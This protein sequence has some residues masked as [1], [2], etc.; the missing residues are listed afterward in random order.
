VRVTDLL[1]EGGHVVGVAAVD[2]AGRALS[3]RARLVVGADG[4]G[5]VVAHQ[6]GCRR[7]HRLRR[8]ALVTYVRG[9]A[10]CGDVG[11]IFVDPPDYAI[12]NPLGPDRVNLSL[13]VPLEHAAPWSD[14]LDTFFA[15]RI[16]QLRHLARRLAGAAWSAPVQ[17]MGPLAYTMTPPQ[18]G[19][20]LLV[21]DAAGFYDPFT[22]EGIFS[23]LRGGELVA[24]TAI[25][26]FRLGD[27]SWAALA[28]YERARR[29]AF[30]GKERFTRALQF[31]VGRRRLANLLAHRLTTRPAL[32]DLLLA[33]AGDYVPPGA[34]LGFTGLPGWC[35]LGRRRGSG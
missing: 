9:L 22:G 10:D 28:G 31:V 18:Q 32:V 35:G 1:R 21:G 13:V 8:M 5:S 11:E 2:A 23:A 6:L 20:V 14:R 7:P 30:G 26:A 12:L 15:A 24:E 4:R 34:L 19:G 16:R 25:R 17:A 29:V 27:W 33:V 3:L